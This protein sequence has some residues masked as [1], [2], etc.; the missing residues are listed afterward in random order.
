[1][2]R[3][4]R[5]GSANTL[6]IDTSNVARVRNQDGNVICPIPYQYHVQASHGQ[7]ETYLLPYLEC[8]ESVPRIPEFV[9][10]FPISPGNG[11]QLATVSIRRGQGYSTTESWNFKQLEY[12]SEQCN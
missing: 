12:V 5:H 1:M 3:S 2:G 8:L 7:L 6:L 4:G 9:N 11:T 10:N